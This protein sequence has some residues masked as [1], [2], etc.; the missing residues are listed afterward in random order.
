MP[1]IF[2]AGDTTS[3]PGY[4]AEVFARG[5]VSQFTLKYSNNNRHKLNQYKEHGTLTARLDEIGLFDDFVK[6]AT[7]KGVKADSKQLHES[8]ELLKHSLYS[9]VTY[10][11]LGMCEHMKFINQTDST[12]LKAIEVLEDGKA[13]P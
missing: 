5:L 9:N 12:V 8:K 10:Q 1:D 4:I 6:F 11:L 7:S 13:F 2:V 3:V